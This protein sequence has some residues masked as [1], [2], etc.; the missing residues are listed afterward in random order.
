[1]DLHGKRIILGSASPRRKDLLAGMDIEFTV[2]TENNFNESAFHASIEPDHDRTTLPLSMAEGKSLGFHRPLLPDEILIT[3]DTAV[4]CDGKMLG[5]PKDR[6][7]AVRMLHILS[8]RKQS[9]TTGVTIRDCGRTD[10]FSDTSHLWFN[11]LT[12]DEI[13]YYIDR[14]KPFDKAGSYAVQEWIGAVG[15]RRIEGSFSTI[16]GLPT[17]LVYSHL[18]KFVE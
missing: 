11:E 14:Y 2:D 3:A 4:F 7:E 9:V 8:G 15:I 6:D 12:D 17:D 1:M 13:V 10:S 5:K 16:I 18:K